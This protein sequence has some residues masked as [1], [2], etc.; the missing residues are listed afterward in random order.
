MVVTDSSLRTDARG[1]LLRECRN[2][3]IVDIDHQSPS[4]QDNTHVMIASATKE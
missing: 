3:R 2:V 4:E 1:V